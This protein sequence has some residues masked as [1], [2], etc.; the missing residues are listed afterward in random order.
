M[1]VDLITQ[2][3]E[4]LETD[5]AYKSPNNSPLLEFENYNEEIE[6]WNFYISRLENHFDL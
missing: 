2:L 3:C 6:T 5:L 4:L 1:S